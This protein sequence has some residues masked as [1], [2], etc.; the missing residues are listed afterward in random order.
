MT[1]KQFV[2]AA[3]LVLLFTLP[4]RADDSGWAGK[5]VVPAHAN[6]PLMYADSAGKDV[7]ASD[8]WY[9]EGRLGD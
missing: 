3:G 8:S 6:V 9:I 4:C 5:K 1:R 2:T 7:V